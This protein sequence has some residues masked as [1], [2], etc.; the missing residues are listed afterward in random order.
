M[1][2]SP[3]VGIHWLYRVVDAPA[4]GN[5]KLALKPGPVDPTTGRPTV[6]V[7]IETRGEG[8]YVVVAPSAGRT[9]PTGEAWTMI[10]GGADTIPSI[11]A[12][13]SDFIYA[14]A[15]L[16]DKMPPTVDDTSGQNMPSSGT[17]TGSG[18]T[19]GTRPGDDSNQRAPWDDRS[20]E[21]TSELPSLRPT[22]HAAF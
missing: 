2:R 7:L 13:E 21:H 18:D 11:T 12:D 8:G 22:S 17:S 9:H 6:E 4:R 15:F 3:S 5:T 20:E 16:F 10:A 19:S 1:E 14:V